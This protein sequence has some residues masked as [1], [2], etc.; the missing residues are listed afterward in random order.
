MQKWVK[1]QFKKNR[2]D[3]V[4]EKKDEKNIYKYRAIIESKQKMRF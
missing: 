3:K 2:P 1:Y 4:W